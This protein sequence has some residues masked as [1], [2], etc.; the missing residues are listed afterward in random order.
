M[1]REAAARKTA[2]VDMMAV[3]HM[4]AAVRM[5]VADPDCCYSHHL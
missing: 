5:M 1:D 2:E 3:A 4:I